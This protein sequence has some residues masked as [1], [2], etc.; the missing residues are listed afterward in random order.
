MAKLFYA[1]IIFYTFAM[2]VWGFSEFDFTIGW[3]SLIAFVVSICLGV[4][5]LVVE[6]LVD[7]LPAYSGNTNY[8]DDDF[9]WPSGR[10]RQ[11]TKPNT[12][13]PKTYVPLVVDKIDKAY[14]PKVEKIEI[15][16][17]N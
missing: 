11:K 5:E 2:S 7:D 17:S 12:T 4:R 16:T 3:L 8:W 1:L 15:V 9:D 13:T 6:P 10:H 14:K